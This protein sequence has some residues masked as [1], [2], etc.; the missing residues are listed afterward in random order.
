MGVRW[1]DFLFSLF[2]ALPVMTAHMKLVINPF[3]L[4]HVVIKEGKIDILTLNKSGKDEAWLN[5]KLKAHDKTRIA[6]VLLAT[7]NEDHIYII[8]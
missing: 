4:P 6:D 1:N 2:R 7:I 8:N 5:S 3:S